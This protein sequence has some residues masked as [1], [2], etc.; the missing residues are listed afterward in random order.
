MN[1]FKLPETLLSRIEDAGINASAPPQQR[2]ADGWLLRF[3][4]GEAK[5][6]RCIQAVADG[7]LP[8]DE[9]LALCA[10][11]F[12]EAGFDAARGIVR[13]LWEPLLKAL[14]DV[15]A[16]PKSALQEWAQG[17]GL[18]LPEYI[19]LARKGPDHAPKFVTEVKVT[20]F[21]PA[22]GDGRSKRIAEQAAATAFLMRQN[23]WAAPPND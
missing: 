6:A 15:S 21:D 4:P 9:R 1:P 13:R 17:Q 5:R 8:L 7:R 11:V 3:S 10:A 12:A 20:G 2:W 18:P 16:D 19:E 23:V 14:P 22:R